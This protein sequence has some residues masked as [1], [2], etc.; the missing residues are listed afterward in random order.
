MNEFKEITPK[1]IAESP[2]KLIGDDWMLVTAGDKEKFNTMTASWGGVGVLWKKN[3]AFIFIRPQRYT[4][5][6]I[7]NGEYLTLSFFDE[8][9]K[10]ALGICGSKSGRDVDKMKETGLTP[11]TT[12]EG[13]YF[14]EA[15]LVM[16][17]KKMYAD[18]LNKDAFLDETVIPEC[19]PGGDYHK[20]YVCS[21]EKVFVK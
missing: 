5:E 14:K 7:E 1:E 15:K 6:F 19:Y 21:I 16:V 12:H 9:Y 3:V 2:L 10:K 13:V 8:S 17:C 18:F 4:F 20:M 11:V